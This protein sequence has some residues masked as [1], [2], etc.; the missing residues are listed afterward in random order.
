VVISNLKKFT[1]YLVNVKSYNKEGPGP[2]STDVKVMTLEDG[3]CFGYFII[4]NSS[5]TLVA[6]MKDMNYSSSTMFLILIIMVLN[7]TI[8][9][10]LSLVTHHVLNK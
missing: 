8:L 9:T 1:E 10:R 5:F 3:N 4:T 7:D 2:A 6:F